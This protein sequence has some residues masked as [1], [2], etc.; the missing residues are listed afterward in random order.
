MTYLTFH[1]LFNLPVLILLLMLTR[2]TLT[3]HHWKWIGLVV[4]IVVLFTYPW[5]SYAVERGIWSFPN[6][7]V[8]YWVGY[9][10]I[11]EILFFLFE[12]VNVSLFVVYLI[13][14]HR[15]VDDMRGGSR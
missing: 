12:A 13:A 6:D 3:T 8:L 7:R 1:L 15:V 2:R 9:L 4:A 11:E 14:R 10:P 5:D